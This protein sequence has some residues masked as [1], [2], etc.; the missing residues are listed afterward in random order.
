MAIHLKSSGA[1]R[2]QSFVATREAADALLICFLLLSFDV[3]GFDVGDWLPL[4]APV[5]TSLW[6][7]GVLAGLHFVFR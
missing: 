4:A 5:V 1:P 3:N 2:W 6:T 7:A